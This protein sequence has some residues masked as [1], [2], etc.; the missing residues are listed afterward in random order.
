MQLLKITGECL[1]TCLTFVL[2]YGAQDSVAPA[3]EFDVV[4]VKRVSSLRIHVPAQ[5]VAVGRPL[6]PCVYMETRVR[7]D[8]TLGKLIEE[9]Y[10]VEERA[11][12]GPDWLKDD[13]FEL[14]ATMSPGSTRDT[15]RLMLRRMLADRFALRCHRETRV[16]IVYALLV[17][18]KGS[19]L[20][21]V[22]DPEHAPKRAASTPLG[23]ISS[24]SF[25]RPGQFFAAAMTMDR[26]AQTLTPEAG[27]P[28]VNLTG[29]PGAYQIDIRWTPD[30]TPGMVPGSQGSDF[31]FLG[32]VQRQ[33]GLRLEKRN[34]PT[35]ILVIDRV[36]RTPTEN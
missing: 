12:V 5:T 7:C 9:A 16:S 33:L 11:I 20:K 10:G 36:N 29:L 18:S 26:L 1:V 17:A 22:S 32:E 14:N 13:V 23:A 31:G 3:A 21:Q 35:E 27:L 15:A 6:R 30:E 24:S 19:K 34:L 8:L 25:R 28:V 2:A 4:S